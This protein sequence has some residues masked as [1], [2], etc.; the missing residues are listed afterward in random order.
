[1]TAEHKKHSGP[2]HGLTESPTAFRFDFSFGPG[3][4]VLCGIV[5]GRTEGG[6]AGI[7]QSMSRKGNCWDNACAESFFKTLK[8]GLET[9]D[10]KQTAQ[11]V[12]DS[13]F[14]Y[15]ETYYNRKRIHSA[16]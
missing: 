7:R 1:M 16:P 5:Q 9:V 12:Q 2:R 10:G 4:T 13:V 11:V 6:E 8:A 3:C 14:E 15:I